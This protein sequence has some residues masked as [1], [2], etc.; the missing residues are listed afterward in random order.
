MGIKLL[1]CRI[2]T[3]QLSWND[4]GEPSAD[5]FDDLYF[6]T[7]DGLL[8]TRYVF[9]EQN[10]LQERWSEWTQPNFVIGETGFGS[11][12]NFLATI[13]CFVQWRNENPHH[14]LRRLY[15]TSFEKYPLTAHDLKNAHKRWPELALFAQYLQDKYPCPISGCHRIEFPLAQKSFVTLDLWLGDIKDTLPSLAYP[16][17]GLIDCWFLDGFAPSKNP[18]MWSLALYENMAKC[19][20]QNATLATFTAAGDVRRGLASVGFS[21]KKVKGYGKKREMITATFERKQQQSSKTSWFARHSKAEQLTDL[22]VVGGGIA[23]A[24]LILALAKQGIN[25]TLYCDDE[26]VAQGASG[27][28]Q[29]GFYPLLNPN[30][31]PISQFYTQAFTF[32]RQLYRPFVN[33]EPALGNFCG[34]LQLALDSQGENRHEK[35]VNSQYF[36]EQL[37]IG[38]N[39]KQMNHSSGLELNKAGLCYPLGGWIS[40]KL[41]TQLLLSDAKNYANVTIRLNSRLKECTPTNEGVTLHFSNGKITKS[42][43]LVLA[44]GHYLSHFPQ[45]KPLP[46]Y[47]T[48]GQV[49][50]IKATPSSIALKTVLCYQGYITP[51]LTNATGQAIHCVGA[52]FERELTKLALSQAIQEENV[53]KLITDTAQSDW[54]QSL[55]NQPLAG[56]L[57]VR[58]SVK[59][60]LPMVGNIP[61]Y[62]Q[63]QR[64]YHDLQKGKPAKAYDDAPYYPNMFLLGGL[65]S[66]GICSA[67]ILAE[68]LVAQLTNTPY[69]LSQNLLDQ[70]NP[71]RYWIKQLKQGKVIASEETKSDV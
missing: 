70:L 22:A 61:N 54:S 63:T 57:G 2:K 56:K 40:P 36:P 35:L 34:V 48:G 68:I 13:A 51:A 30:H 42:S 69:P 11:G 39:N 28:L 16:K 41:A 67:P 18:E 9:I 14:Q 15:F 49:S 24:S 27:N 26:E 59:D 60:H 44:N 8:E 5:K 31:D 19:T 50:H 10:R 65:G 47:A 4:K 25:S 29:G 38:L 20:K 12:L 1:S 45:T 23:S 33:N 43:A 7:N 6:S 62:Q 17:G 64:Q 52:S 46:L 58:M 3:A 37:V 32:A 66:R 71:N 53:G 21:I 55:A